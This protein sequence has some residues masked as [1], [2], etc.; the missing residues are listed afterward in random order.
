MKVSPPK[1]KGIF[2]FLPIRN[3]IK[4]KFPFSHYGG[5]VL[6]PLLFSFHMEHTT[7]PAPHGPGFIPFVL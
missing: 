1:K 5:A 4:I 7:G 3:D 2:T 6:T